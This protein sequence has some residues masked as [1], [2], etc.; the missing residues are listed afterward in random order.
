MAALLRAAQLYPE[1]SL[2]N[3]IENVHVVPP[4]FPSIRKI[5]H[6]LWRLAL[7]IDSKA[8]HKDSAAWQGTKEDY[9][10][11][12][13]I[14]TGKVSCVS[15]RLMETPVNLSSAHPAHV[16]AQTHHPTP[17]KGFPPEDGRQQVAEISFHAG[18]MNH[19]LASNTL[20]APS[21]SVGHPRVQ[22]G[23]I[24]ATQ[25]TT[26]A[27]LQGL[28]FF[29]VPLVRPCTTGCQVT[30]SPALNFVILERV[31]RRR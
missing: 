17:R 2:T 14:T 30:L 24:S 9:G 27:R 15:P 5:A 8:C 22:I 3:E 23:F 18:I 11:R 21:L 31:C 7:G 25:L 13:S 28:T 10:N 16:E 19:P 6:N 12:Q 26:A 29:F 1:S 20:G 4:W